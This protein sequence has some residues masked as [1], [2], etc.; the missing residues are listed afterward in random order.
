M[1]R[2]DLLQKIKGL[3]FNKVNL[4]ES[5]FK[6]VLNVYNLHED[7]FNKSELT[8]LKNKLS[9]F[10]AKVGNKLE[11]H[12]RN[13]DRL[14]LKE[15]VWLQEEFFP[16]LVKRI[17][18]KEGPGRK[19]KVWE[20]LGE[21]SKRA[22]IAHLAE[23]NHEALALASLKSAATESN[24]NKNN[25]IFIVKKALDPYKANEIRKIMS[26]HEPVKMKVEDALSLKIQC[27]LSDEQYQIIRN[28]SLLQNA[29]IYPSLHKILTEKKKYYPD[30]MIFS[31]TS[32]V[33]SLQSL[34]NHTLCRVLSL[35]SCNKIF[36]E[37]SVKDIN[38]HGIMHFKGGFDGASSQSLYKQKYLD[39]TLDEV[40]KNEESIFQTSIVPLKLTVNDTVIWYNKKPSSTH[41]CRPVCLQ[42]KKETNVLIKEE[43]ERLRI[44]IQ[45]LEP[46][47]VSLESKPTES[48]MMTAI[49]KYN[50][51]LTMFDGKVINALTSTTSSQSCN[52]CSAK[53]TEMN[54]IKLIR[55]K[56]VNKE[57][58]FFGL[59][60]LHCWIRCFEYILHLGYKLKIRS[61]YAKTSEQKES[62]KERKAFIQKKFREE[63]SLIVDMP[64]QGFGNT[65]DG[66][67]AR[68][69]FEESITFS[70]II[71]VDV[72]IISR[73]ETILKAVCSG[74]DLDPSSFQSYCND[75]TDKILSEY[76]WYVI[77]PSVHKLLEHGLQIANA[78]E[79]PIGVYSEESL[80]A[81]NKEIKNTRI[82]HSCKISR[83]NVMKNQFN[84]LM[85]RSDPV[86]SSIQFTNH[87]CENGKLLPIEVLSLLKQS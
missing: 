45:K 14:I 51:D 11:K 26:M 9:V 1:K 81:L 28:S 65:N 70:E 44:E 58:L 34:F 39:T 71:G 48:S 64:K 78:L 87:R 2:I 23:N 18:S 36:S 66:N 29:N 84:Y 57:A 68:R 30:N 47:V 21:R 60:P 31:E 25:F 13:Y 73:L 12:N 20:N 67:T 4:L 49:I 50:L 56:P 72:D 3:G 8:N 5:L 16:D 69:A 76:N 37:L 24:I 63:L 43:E 15:G 33:C 61:F 42:Y 40:I 41:F 6:E 17:K 74:Y 32:A 38:Q 75:T 22:K 86:I 27:D 85:I 52:V 77:P 80:E 82:N 10:K 7:D 83:I 46:F 53:P 62:V 35:N 19:N 79:L 59:S 55:S 54:D